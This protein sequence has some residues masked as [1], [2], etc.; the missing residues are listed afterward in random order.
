[1]NYLN[2]ANSQACTRFFCAFFLFYE[3]L[4]YIYNRKDVTSSN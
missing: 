1:M 2:I 3:N 4:Y